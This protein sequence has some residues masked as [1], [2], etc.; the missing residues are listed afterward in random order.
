MA[1]GATGKGETRKMSLLEEGEQKISMKLRDE[2]K[3]KM[4]ANKLLAEAEAAKERERLALL[5][6][7]ELEERRKNIQ[8][9][10]RENSREIH[11]N[12]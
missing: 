4:L 3:E 11:L 6:A 1:S 5:E 8:V 2:K 12:N 9:W 10:V 7:E